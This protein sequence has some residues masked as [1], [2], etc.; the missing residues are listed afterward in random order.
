M[1]SNYDFLTIF[2][3]RYIV[4]QNSFIMISL[5]QIYVRGVPELSF[6]TLPNIYSTYL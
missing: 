1:K 6:A 4:I 5:L 3:S 2:F